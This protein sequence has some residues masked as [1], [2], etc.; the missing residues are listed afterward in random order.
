M[1]IPT[2]STSWNPIDSAAAP[3]VTPN[4]GSGWD[5]RRYRTPLAT[6]NTTRA[7]I[8]TSPTVRK[9]R[10]SWGPVGDTTRSTRNT[11]R[12]RTPSATRGQRV[13]GPPGGRRVLRAEA[14]IDLRYAV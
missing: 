10:S 12:A 11:A 1:A 5:L 4:T 7:A 8:D 9:V 14:S 3:R 2:M 13:N 6:A